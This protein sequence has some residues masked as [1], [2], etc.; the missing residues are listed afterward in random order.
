[1][2]FTTGPYQNHGPG[3][4]NKSPGIDVRALLLRGHLMATPISETL[5]TASSRRREEK[6]DRGSSRASYTAPTP[7]PSWQIQQTVVADLAFH[8]EIDVHGGALGLGLLLPGNIAAVSF[9]I[10][11]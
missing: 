8:F 7:G 3:G 5:Q 10:C 2:S 4:D 11:S 1:M 6:K 9:H